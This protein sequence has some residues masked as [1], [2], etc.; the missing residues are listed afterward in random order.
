MCK[1]AKKCIIAIDGGSGV[2]KT[3]VSKALSKKLGIIYIDTGAMYRATGLYFLNNKIEINDKNIENNL[4]KINVDLKINCDGENEV[5]LNG[6]NVTD[7]IRTEEVSMAASNVSKNSK[8]REHLVQKQRALAGTQSVVIEGRDAATVIFPNADV[9]LFFTSN[10]DIRSS[11][12]YNDLKKKDSSVKLENVKND[13]IKRD[14]QDST[15]TDSP[16]KK[17][18]GSILI[19]TSNCTVEETTNSILDILRERIGLI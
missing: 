12:R 13:L 3:T 14:T 19:D 16:L 8:V 6:E 11:R 7:K 17:A 10:I 18:K 15:R 9:K 4:E 2:G 1:L 5:Y